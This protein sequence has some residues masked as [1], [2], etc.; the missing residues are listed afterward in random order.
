MSA[1]RKLSGCGADILTFIRDT[2]HEEKA[3]SRR[4]RG[5]R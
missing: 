3:V 1:V 5:L 2:A 4:L